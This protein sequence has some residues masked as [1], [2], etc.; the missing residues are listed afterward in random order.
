VASDIREEQER[1][2]AELYPRI[3]DVLQRHGEEDV[4][5]ERRDYHLID[6]NL[7]FHRLRIETEELK[8]ITP[9]VVES[10]QQQ[11]NG[12]PDWEIVMA[13]ASPDKAVRP[14]MI[15]IIRDD[16]IIDGLQRQYLPD[17][18]RTIQYEGSR[19]LGSKFGDVIYS[20]PGPF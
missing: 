20:G 7:G 14:G 8:F 5:G 6:D 1:Q 15:L 2:W 3:R 11:L 13:I 17:E 19:P 10:L 18:L 9:V 12:Y 4:A 16:E